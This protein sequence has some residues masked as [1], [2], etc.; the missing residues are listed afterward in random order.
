M[1]S[2]A[3]SQAGGVQLPEDFADTLRQLHRARD[4]RLG[5]TLQAARDAGWTVRLLAHALGVSAERPRQIIAAGKS[6]AHGPLPEIPTVPGV[7]PKRTTEQPPEAAVEPAAVDA[8]Q[9]GSPARPERPEAE[10]EGWFADWRAAFARGETEEDA[11]WLT[12]NDYEPVNGFPADVFDPTRVRCIRCG[13]ERD[14]IL[15][16]LVR[17]GEK[18]PVCKHPAGPPRQLTAQE[19]AERRSIRGQLRDEIY[20]EEAQAAGWEPVEPRPTQEM[21]RWRLRC[22]TCGEV[23]LARVAKG[24]HKVPCLHG[25]TDKEQVAQDRFVAAGW[26]VLRR[27]LR[28]AV[29]GND[30]R[31]QIRCPVCGHEAFRAAARRVAAC[32]HPRTPEA[33]AGEER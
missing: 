3:P 11:R 16:D 5:A 33:D 13:A 1:T 28:G 22:T 2:D 26:E 19:R 17:D 31:W 6:K 15:G 21:T 29:S 14:V 8:E 23:A 7:V 10:D 4:P 25:P 18:L 30:A 27:P 32:T 9:P 20:G 24:E 12:M